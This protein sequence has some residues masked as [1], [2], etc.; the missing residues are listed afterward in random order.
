MHTS[1]RIKV[2]TSLHSALKARRSVPLARGLA[3]CASVF[4]IVLGLAVFAQSPQPS[5]GPESIRIDEL[6]V[7]L[8]HLASDE[9]RGR[10]NGT[11]EIDAA[12]D[13]IAEVFEENGLTPAGGNGYFQEFEIERL[14][15]GPDNALILSGDRDVRLNVRSDFLPFPGSVD[16]AVSASMV[17]VGYGIRAPDSDYDD[18]ADVNLDGQIAVALDGVPLGDDP[19]SPFNALTDR[20]FS[21]IPDKA[22]NVEEA[23]AV[24]LVIVQGPGQ[25]SS[26]PLRFWADALRPNLPPRRSLMRVA[27]GAAD[28]GIPIAVVARGAAER[29]VPDLGSRQSEINETLRSQSAPLS[30]SAT[31]RVDFDRDGYVARNVIALIEGSDPDLADE[32]IVVG[33]H[34]DH[35]GED[36]GRIWNGADDD[37]S[38]TT[39]LLELA[40]AFSGGVRPGRSVLLSAW[41]GE[42]KGMLGSHRYVQYPV[43]PLENTVAMFQLD[44]IGRNE[45]HGPDEAEG[46][47]RERASEN[48]NMINLLG[49]A[50]SPDMRAAVEAANADVGLE[51]RFRYDYG[52]QNLIR[53]SDHWSFLSARIPA[54]FIFGGLHPDYHTPNDTAD[55]INYEKLEK[56]VRLVY[57]T[58]L[59]VGNGTAEPRFT[60]P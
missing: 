42:E 58:L 47:L 41:A 27:P 25:R 50:F 60:I 51:L 26:I 57:Q 10:G 55:K 23:G 52:A 1:R 19:D 15:V 53:R 18:L 37:A 31:L 20:D 44:M 33:A 24:G 7:K 9:F 16:G 14:S 38:G 54:L 30:S 46:F 56:V 22:R 3:V 48:G 13:Y 36:N 34:Y 59:D 6:R 32:A 12:A 5:F 49:S 39:A 2:Q 17:F 21:S 40:E 45:E 8:F 43:V 35:D 11:P 4:A 29:L 28:P